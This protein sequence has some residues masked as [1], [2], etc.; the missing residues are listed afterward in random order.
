MSEFPQF[1]ENG[2]EKLFFPNVWRETQPQQIVGADCFLPQ[3]NLNTD[4]NLI[5]LKL[6]AI[7]FTEIFSSLRNGA[8]KTYPDKFMQIMV[9]F[10]KGLHCPPD[11]QEQEC[12]EFP[13]YAAFIQYSPMNPYVTP[14]EI[15]DGYEA[16]PFL[17]DGENGVDIPNY[18]HFDVLV[19]PDALTLDVDW[20]TDIA[21]QLPTVTIMVNGTGTVYIKLLNQAQGGLAVITLDNPPNLADIILGIVT[22]A[23]NI[24]DLNLDVVSVPPETAIEI[25]YPLEITT[26]GIHTIYVVFL[27][28]LD[29]SLIP[30][31]FGGG[32]RGV[33]LCDF[34]SE[35]DM[36]ITNI[37][38]EDCNL[39]KQI[40]G[41]WETVDGWENINDCIVPTTL[42]PES[43]DAALPETETIVEITN[44]ITT[45]ETNITEVTNIVNE[46][47]ASP[48][49]GNVLPSFSSDSDGQI[50]GGASYVADKIDAAVSDTWSH[51][52]ST[53]YLGMLVAF[54]NGGGWDSTLLSSLWTTALSIGGT[55]VPTEVTANNG[56]IKNAFYCNDFDRTAVM[57]EISASVGLT[58]NAKNAINAAIAACTDTQINQW[59]YIGRMAVSASCGCGGEKV[60]DFTSSNQGFVANSGNRASYSA[61]NGWGQ[62]NLGYG[63]IIVVEKTFTWP[64][65]L[66]ITHAI[67]YVTN[68]SGG[69]SFLYFYGTPYVNDSYNAS[70][71]GTDGFQ[72]NSNIVKGT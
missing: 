30:L 38:L 4:E 16:I 20:F 52:P 32:F 72:Y 12:T 11:L 5:V 68:Q 43:V 57:A 34:I 53:D 70:G 8:E 18:E 44:S 61:G 54:L 3:V 59:R 29:D 41:S 26:S 55:S 66:I 46:I 58:T 48:T 33:Q 27:P 62:V 67:A 37:R 17:V 69:A 7:E 1:E 6:S 22:G 50:C 39:E 45:N 65:D 35:G 51:L 49:I 25:I 42:S 47:Q 71:V 23:D 24:V 2:Q 28:I 40:E 10:L 9:N 13:T 14:D 36:G 21:G 19:P 60:W 15:P 63:N 56:I 31:R 64:S